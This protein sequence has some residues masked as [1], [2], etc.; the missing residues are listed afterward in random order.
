MLF[1]FLESQ[2]L[3]IALQL[4]IYQILDADHRGYVVARIRYAL[5][6]LE[7]HGM[8]STQNQI[9]SI[10]NTVDFRAKSITQK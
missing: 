4:S 1:I 2:N 5:D 6:F 8:W 3:R 9:I 7:D 10:V